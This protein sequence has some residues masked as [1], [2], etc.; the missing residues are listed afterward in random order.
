L[1]QQKN[2]ISSMTYQTPLQALQ[3]YTGKEFDISPSPLTRWLKPIVVS[4]ERGRLCFSYTVREEMCN[5]M[6]TLHGGISAAIIDDMIG[7]VLYSLEEEFFYTTVN[8]AV[9]YF[10]PAFKD[11][12]ILAEAFV[13]KKGSQVVHAQCEIWNENKS[14]MIAR[15]SSNLLKT[16]IRKE[17]HR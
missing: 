11:N 8:L 15:G 2:K 17:N 3:A 16:R 9:D 14:R 10:A 12:K 5:P 13:V 1:E 4:A 7:A 6:K